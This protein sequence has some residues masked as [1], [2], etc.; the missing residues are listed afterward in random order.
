MK[1]TGSTC[2]SHLIYCMTNPAF[3][4]SINS[5]KYNRPCYEHEGMAG[6]IEVT[7]EIDVKETDLLV[8]SKIWDQWYYLPQEKRD[9][10][11]R[12]ATKGNYK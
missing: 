10:L 6:Y 1:V 9:E 3:N 4:K 11:Y 7:Y 2:F 12:L 5:I 8:F